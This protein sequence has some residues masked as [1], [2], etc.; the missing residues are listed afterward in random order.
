MAT[1]KIAIDAWVA[2]SRSIAAMPEAASARRSTTAT[3]GCEPSRRATV[4]D[5]D[6]DP[7]RPQ[8]RGCLAFE[9]VIMADDERC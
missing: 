9:F 7:T 2:R 6:R 5:P 3:S 8:Q 1:A 4:D